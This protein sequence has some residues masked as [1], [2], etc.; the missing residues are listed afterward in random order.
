MTKKRVF[1]VFS[2]IFVLGISCTRLKLPDLTDDDGTPST[3]EAVRNAM[4]DAW[5]AGGS[6]KAEGEQIKCDETAGFSKTVQLFTGDPKEIELMLQQIHN[7][8]I[9]NEVEDGV[10]KT[11]RDITLLASTMDVSDGDYNKKAETLQYPYRFEISQPSSTSLAANGIKGNAFEAYMASKKADFKTMSSNGAEYISLYNWL[12][13]ATACFPSPQYSWK[14]ECYNLRTWDSV[15]D[16]PEFV[17]KK[18]DCGGLPNCKMN[19]KNVAYDLVAEVK[20]AD[21]GSISR[22]KTIFTLKFSKDVPYLSR[23]VSAC[24]QGLGKYQDQPYI[25]TICTDVNDFNRGTDFPASGQSCH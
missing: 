2:L 17:R 16:A 6:D 18:Q 14:P 11:F 15:E 22:Q 24:Y 12:S 8:E 13:Y 21:N 10:N 20:D 1:Y 3:P 25:A 19:I 7:I 23:L 4:I 5:V 9:K